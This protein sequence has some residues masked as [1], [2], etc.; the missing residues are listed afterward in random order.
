MGPMSRPQFGFIARTGR[1]LWT[2]PYVVVFFL[3]Q[4]ALGR[5]TLLHG[6]GSSPFKLALSWFSVVALL[7]QASIRRYD[8]TCL[9]YILLACPVSLSRLIHAIEHV[10]PTYWTQLRLSSYCFLCSLRTF[11]NYDCLQTLPALL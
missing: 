9:V 2:P 7:C 8:T 10:S 3:G 11:W 4:P 6:V 1:F 5:T